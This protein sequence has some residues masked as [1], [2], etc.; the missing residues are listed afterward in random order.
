[1]SNTVVDI[2]LKSKLQDRTD[3]FYW[4][5][6]ENRQIFMLTV[7]NF[8]MVQI[9][10]KWEKPGVPWCKHL[11]IY[12]F[13]YLLLFFIRRAA[14]C[15]PE[16]TIICFSTARV[17][18]FSSLLSYYHCYKK[19]KLWQKLE[20]GRRTFLSNKKSFIFIDEL[21]ASIK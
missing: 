11:Y 7:Q 13:I 15:L 9:Y 1:M 2:W 6:Q 21:Q 16:T 19:K 4:G 17:K 14:P 20:I 5:Q 8:S 10:T 12:T 3:H 18:I